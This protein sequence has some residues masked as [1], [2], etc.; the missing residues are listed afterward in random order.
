MPAYEIPLK[1]GSSNVRLICKGEEYPV[2]IDL[3]G[4]TR[5]GEDGVLKFLSLFGGDEFV[6]AVLEGQWFKYNNAGMD[7]D[8]VFTAVLDGAGV[9]EFEGEADVA[10]TV[11]IGT[12]NGYLPFPMMDGFEIT[13]AMSVPIDDTGAVADRDISL[14]FYLVR[15]K[16]ADLAYNNTE[17]LY[18]KLDVDETGI[19][20]QMGK[21][22]NSVYTTLFTGS[23]YDDA[24]VRATGDIEAL[25]FRWVFHGKPGTSGAHV[26]LY[27]RQSDTLDNAEAAEENETTTS[28]YDLSTLNFNVGYP[29]FMISSQNTDY[30][31]DGQE[32]KAGYIR[33]EYPE[34][35]VEQTT[36]DANLFLNQVELWDGDPDGSGVRVYDLDHKFSGDIYLQNG[37]IRLK[38]DEDAQYGATLSGYSSG[39]SELL[40][41]MCRGYLNPGGQYPQYYRVKNINFVSEEKTVLT[42][43]V[44][45]DVTVD[46]DYYYEAE[47]TMRKGSYT[48]EWKIVKVF[49]S[50]ELRIY[51]YEV[52]SKNRFGYSGDDYYGDDDL[53]LNAINTTMTD[54]FAMIFDNAGAAFLI[55][56]ATNK[57]P[58]Q[59][60]YI[61]DGSNL[62]YRD[63]QP[64]TIGSG[65][66]YVSLVPYSLIADLFKEAEVATLAGGAD[67]EDLADDSGTSARLNAQNETVAYTVVGGT[68]IPEGRYLAVF[69]I[70]DTNQVAGD[71]GIQVYNTDDSIHR[72]EKMAEVAKTVTVA[73]V[74][75]SLV[76]DVNAADVSGTDNIELRVKKLL[77]TANVIYVDYFL[78]VPCGNRMY[79]PQDL[80]HAAICSV[81]L[82]RRVKEK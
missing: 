48:L 68:D 76:F 6:G 18:I 8:Q 49:P 17:L 81:S 45:E 79:F 47:V 41:R 56:V 20:V 34:F 42:I 10:G 40:D 77:A 2:D 70:K 11:G 74:Y 15:D 52:G 19:L 13:V 66:I 28:P 63:F 4:H 72:N 39:W 27:M 60:F 57:K 51:V 58:D 46:D 67:T 25:I 29:A 24:S 59:S 12:L 44:D 33:V 69:R 71:V 64:T 65:V 9:L 16:R 80:A 26:H 37:L 61:A 73:F 53:G 22:V 31:D 7:A 21:R 36:A 30:F 55:S 62:D 3:A 82:D 38:I 23:T 78:I 35:T 75:Y 54:N 43:R 1:V 5:T 14:T 32:A 50:Q